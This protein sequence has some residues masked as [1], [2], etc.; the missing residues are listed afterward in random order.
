[1][2]KLMCVGSTISHFSASDV[3]GSVCEVTDGDEEIVH[4][5]AVDV[6][7]ARERGQRVER[8]GL[9]RL[10]EIQLAARYARHQRNGG[11]L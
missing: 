10:C 3:V 2:W 5:F 8:G 9:E 6:V 7:A 11:A 1:M 4:G